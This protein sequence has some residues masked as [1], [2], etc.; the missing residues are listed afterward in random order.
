MRAVSAVH[1]SVPAYAASPSSMSR[2]WRSGRGFLPPAHWA[3]T[4]VR[5][6]SPTA[7]NAAMP[8]SSWLP[9]CPTR[10]T[11]LAPAF[12]TS[13]LM[14]PPANVS[15]S[16][17]WVPSRRSESTMMK[18]QEPSRRTSAS[19]YL[20]SRSG[21]C[22]AMGPGRKPNAA[23]TSRGRRTLAI[24]PEMPT[25]S[26]PR[27]QSTPRKARWDCWP[28]LPSTSRVTYPCEPSACASARAVKLLPTPPDPPVTNAVTVCLFPLAIPPPMRVENPV[29]PP[30][31]RH[32]QVPSRQKG[33][34]YVR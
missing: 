27:L 10:N 17:H 32:M 33:S 30:H 5:S 22:G 8:S 3:A 25:S 28:G 6:G 15:G 20:S 13:G 16:S 24:A 26:M 1:T 14:S 11:S 18:S 19:P 21:S 23:L 2:H 7:L 12:S 4:M 9:D 34:T 31:R 29:E